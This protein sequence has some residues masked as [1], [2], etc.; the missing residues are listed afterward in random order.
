MDT[1]VKIEFNP[2]KLILAQIW[3][4]A[5]L[6]HT[7]QLP[8]TQITSHP[9]ASSYGDYSSQSKQASVLG[10]Q[11]RS[12]F[13]PE[14][15][16]RAWDNEVWEPS[17]NPLPPSILLRTLAHRR[18]CA[19]A[20]EFLGFFVYADKS[21]IWCNRGRGGRQRRVRSRSPRLRLAW[22]GGTWYFSCRRSVVD[23]KGTKIEERRPKNGGDVAY[24][25]EAG[26]KFG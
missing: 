21:R 15:G 5:S 9:F 13:Q 23:L 16:Q 3:G 20:F 1:D 12:Q 14:Q 10:L 7:Q 17:S 4:S 26:W 2:P 24:I 11:L 25:L 18:V 19:C 8:R 22:L 6:T